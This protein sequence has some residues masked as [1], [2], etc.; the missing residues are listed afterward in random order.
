VCQRKGYPRGSKGWEDVREAVGGDVVGMI[1]DDL[2]CADDDGGVDERVE[3]L[4]RNTRPRKH[5]KE[6]TPAG[7]SV[8]QHK[9]QW[10]TMTLRSDPR[11]VESQ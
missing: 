8:P 3:P 11:A 7:A 2:P 5:P 9:P 10:L 4:I 6:Q 1:E